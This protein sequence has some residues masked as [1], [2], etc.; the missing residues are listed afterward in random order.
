MKHKESLY[1][2]HPEHSVVLLQSHIAQ[3]LSSAS[4]CH[5]GNER[6]TVKNAALVPKPKHW[7][8]V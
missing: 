2:F 3:V 4:L 8:M 5:V 7:G 6:E 1:I